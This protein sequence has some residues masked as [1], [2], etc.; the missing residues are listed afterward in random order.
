MKFEILNKFLIK[1]LKKVNNLIT[2]NHIF[3]ILENILLIAKD[4]TITLT[5]TN[6][7]MEIKIIILDVTLLEPGSITVSGKKILNI[8]QNLPKDHNLKIQYINNKL[9]IVSHNNQYLLATLPIKNFP[10]LKISEN[11]NNFVISQNDLKD[12]LCATYFS[13]AIQDL[14]NFLNGLFF[15]VRNQHLYAVATDGYRIAICKKPLHNLDKKKY[16][17]IILPRKGVLELIKL[18]NYSN[19]VISINISNNYFQIEFK[20]L[21]FTSKIITEKFPDYTSLILTH[22]SKKMILNTTLFKEALSRVAILSNENFRGVNIK[23]DQNKLLITTSNQHDEEASE[24]ID[25]IYTNIKIKMSINAS[26]MIDILNAIQDQEICLSKND[27]THSIQ[28]QAHHY[29]IAPKAIYII[30]PL[31]A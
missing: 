28:I 15:E 23:N 16:N 30:M 27:V 17:S 2:R 4:N 22:I 10:N 19:E 1:S 25:I 26:Y 9:K 5:S 12:V 6:I 13:M 29:K 7:D 24:I 20:N 18:L 14:R 31:Y 11:Q 3:P 21:I 8:C